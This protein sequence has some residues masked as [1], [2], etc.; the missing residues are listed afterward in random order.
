M[1]CGEGGKEGEKKRR[2]EG[3]RK[4][5]RKYTSLI[6]SSG[7]FYKCCGEEITKIKKFRLHYNFSR[8]MYLRAAPSLILSYIIY[9]TSLHSTHTTQA[10]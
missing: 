9:S 7:K 6:R 8:I 4:E 10:L 1:R 2:K 5:G 3:G